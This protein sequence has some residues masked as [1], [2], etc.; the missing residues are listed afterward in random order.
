MS[1]RRAGGLSMRRTV[2][3]VIGLLA[4]LPGCAQ[5][6]GQ[7]T[8][9]SKDSPELRAIAVLE[10]TGEAGKPKTSRI[11]P[12]AVLD[13]G[14]L[15]DGGIYLARPEPLALAGQVEYELQQNGKAVGLFDIKNAGQEQGSWVGYGSWKP[16][17]TARPRPSARELAQTRI[18]DDVQSDQP[19]LHRK[20]HAGDLRAR[21]VPR[22]GF[23]P[24][25]GHR[26]PG[27]IAHP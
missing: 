1:S 4:A 26:L 7:V 16:M 25:D 8:K 13:G 14:Q 22:G 2:L 11:V 9:S 12:V 19:V 18:D 24:G 3:A 15:Q 6:P 21:Q 23:G 20:H 10:W 5:Y 27:S 17:P